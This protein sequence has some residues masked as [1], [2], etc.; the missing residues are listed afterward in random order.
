M[1][2]KSRP[3]KARAVTASLAQANID[4]LNQGVSQQPPHLRLV[5]QAAV[6]INGWSSPVEGLCKRRPTQLTSKVNGTPMAN[7]YLEMIDVLPD[8]QYAVMLSP[9]GADINLSIMRNGVEPS[10]DL[11]GTGMTKTGVGQITCATGSY[12][13]QTSQADLYKKYVLI[14]SG[15]L[16]LLLNREQAT[17]LDAATTPASVN[18][19]IIFIQGVS[20][21]LTYSV[22]VNGGT[23]ITSTTPKPTDTANTISTTITANDLATKLGADTT[24]SVTQVGAIIYVKKKDG[25]DFTLTID[26]GRSGTLARVIKRSVSSTAGLPTQAWNGMILKVDASPADNRDDYWVQFVADSP[27]VNIGPGNWVEVAE[28]GQQ[29]KFNADT[30]PLVIYRRA[31]GVIFV[32]PAD[33]ATRTQT[34]NGTSYSFTFPKWGERSTGNQITNPVP[35]IAGQ[36]VRD[37]VFFRGRY[38]ICA[39]QVVQFSATDKPFMFFQDSSTQLV[40]SDPFDVVATGEKGEFLNWMLPIDESLLAFSAS[41]Q[42]QVRA[43]DADV[44]TP[45]TAIILRLSNIE[46]NANIRPKIAGPNVVFATQEFGYTHYREY[47]FFDS[48]TRR[49]GLNLGGN[50]SV[51]MHV[52]KYVKGLATHWDVGESLDF[53]VCRTDADPKKLY[54]YKYLWGGA[55]EGMA[56]SQSS[57]SEWV[58][59]GDIQWVKFMENELYMLMSYPDGTYVVHISAAELQDPANPEFLL[60]RVIKYPECNQGPAKTDDVTATYDADTDLTTFTLPYQAASL[61]RVV[62]RMDNA[63]LKNL[64]LGSCSSGNT[65]VADIRGDYRNDKLVIGSEYELIYEFSPAYKAEK[66]Q[67]RKRIV[68][69]LDGRLQLATWTTHHFQSGRYDVRVIRPMRA[70]SVH[71]FRARFLNVS[72]N[73]LTTEASVLESGMF[74]VPV[75]CR[76]THTRIRVESKSWLPVTITG[77]SWE[78]NYNDRSKSLN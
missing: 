71:P 12:L 52:P 31:P 53:F 54:V 9:V 18:E 45:R 51:N 60:D 78:G 26:D 76:N 10:I 6:Q 28:P 47:Q 21:E 48:Q 42:F 69:D 75:Y 35:L 39:G 50:Q 19:A 27:S 63:R 15:P 30:F 2:A 34:V 61:T 41:S 37:H 74:R 16:A 3:L 66:D 77:A 7:L 22:K 38:V 11:H 1:R 55:S 62:V 25:S 44:L 8:E 59:D 13:H 68:G 64:A 70:D 43:A 29:Y 57:W 24:L 4:S 67:A 23:A 73:T 33:G 5:G 56:K 20:Y 36:R 46:T 17:A 58:F 32:G 14:N 72:N 40:D 49:L 65:I